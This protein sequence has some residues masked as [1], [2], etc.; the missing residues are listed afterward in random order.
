MI[1]RLNCM[2]SKDVEGDNV[3]Q[4]EGESGLHGEV[5][6]EICQCSVGEVVSI[7]MHQLTQCFIIITR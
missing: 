7:K 3:G 1:Q 2:C 4:K 6:R 5:V